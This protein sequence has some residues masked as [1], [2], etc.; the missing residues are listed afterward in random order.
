MKVTVIKGVIIERSK[1][2]SFEELC[3]AVG[4]RDDLVI[5]MVEQHLIHPSGH[6]PEDWQFDD[7]DLKRA[8]VA[9]N[10]YRDLEINL[11]GI[12]LALDLLEKIEDLQTRIRIL[13]KFE[14]M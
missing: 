13:E 3:Q 10:F 9:A 14:E 6:S 8:K 11:E 1:P 4:L 2:L 5:E 7:T 12:A